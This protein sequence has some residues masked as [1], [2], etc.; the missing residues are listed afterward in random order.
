MS[1]KNHDQTNYTIN[2]LGPSGWG[3]TTMINYFNGIMPKILSNGKI[4]YTPTKKKEITKI[5]ISDI[6]LKF[7]DYPGNKSEFD[8]I[9]DQFHEKSDIYLIFRWYDCID[10]VYYEDK[11]PK[12]SKILYLMD[13]DYF[14][15]TEKHHQNILNNILEVCKNLRNANYKNLE[16]K[17]FIY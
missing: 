13:Y 9:S 2:V 15:Q 6:L 5:T 16:N 12:D 4:L 10:H 3:K 1:L 11:V 14:Y 7:V 17:L 8:E